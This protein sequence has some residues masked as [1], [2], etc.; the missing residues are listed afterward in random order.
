MNNGFFLITG[1]SRGIGE[2]LA[3][4]LLEQG[5][6]VLGVSRTRS[7]ALNFPK[8]HH[9]AFDL[10]N[11]PR[12]SE[13]MDE[14]RAIAEDHRFDF[15]CL[16]NNASATEPIGPIE[17]CAPSEID[18]HVGIGL[19]GPMILTSMF[20][21]AFSDKEVRK[22]VAFVS[23]DPSFLGS[24]DNTSVYE[25]CKAAINI[26]AQCVGLEQKD[27]PCEFEVVSIGPGMVDTSMQQIARSKTSLE[28]AGASF[29]QQAY[30][31]GR[32]QVP[33]RVA[34]KICTILGE[35]YEPGKYVSVS[36]V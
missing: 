20:I 9:L 17:K 24:S 33:A 26:F 30:L 12:L 32:L 31:D 5:S 7:Q 6:T 13:V 18:A 21:R 14:A 16:V 1:T 25:S 36:D 11:T 23:S 22:K 19:I 27:M 28:F 2:A 4:T 34:E 35:R 10:V 29:F 3:R 8:Y 15:L